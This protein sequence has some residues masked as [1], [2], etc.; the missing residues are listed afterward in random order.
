MKRSYDLKLV[1][2]YIWG[3]DIEGVSIDELESDPSFMLEVLE[4]SKD[5]NMYELCSDNVKCDYN[6]VRSVIE[7]FKD[8]LEFVC[9]VADFYLD[10]LD[11]TE[12]LQGT[13]YCELNIIMSSLCGRSLNQYAIIVASF[14]E[15]ER[16]RASL[17]INSSDDLELIEES[18]AGFFISLAEYEDNPIILDFIAKRMVNE[19]LYK[20]RDN[21]L[22]YLIHSRFRSVEDFE[23]FGEFVFL[24]NCISDYDRALSTYVFDR[25]N[26]SEFNTF[27]E[28]LAKEIGKVKNNWDSYMNRINS[29][30][31]GVFNQEF[32][33]Y[34]LDEASYGRL[35]Y[36]EIV[37]YVANRLGR[38][39]EFSKFDFD[40]SS[41]Y[42]EEKYKILETD[43]VNNI[44]KALS[45]ASKLFEKD[46]IEDEY[47]DYSE[48][49]EK[50]EK[51]SR[52]LKPIKFQIT[53]K[54]KRGIKL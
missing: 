50:E 21:N 13:S 45:I 31:I 39:D 18:K 24:H 16:Y 46:V 53:D 29:W 20:E 2:D 9:G 36:D 42:D 14:Y 17:C 22:E 1:Y 8:D 6:F 40:F 30:R 44:N 37:S 11:D 3:N 54:N 51:K 35:S 25:A 33:S 12:K 52:S 26:S 38:I 7:L 49:E 41:E 48:H 4:R 34:M 19:S 10:S 47:D 32:S 28:Q 27:F 5:K 23:K 15:Y 43:D